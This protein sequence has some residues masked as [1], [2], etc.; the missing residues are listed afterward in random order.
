METFRC[1]KVWHERRGYNDLFI[2]TLASCPD[3]SMSLSGITTRYMCNVTL[4]YSNE[5]ILF[6]SDLSDAVIAGTENTEE[7]YLAFSQR[8]RKTRSVSFT[9]HESYKSY[10]I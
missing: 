4:G 8:F 5:G 2:E 9:T 3:I 7:A 10:N 1:Q 6:S